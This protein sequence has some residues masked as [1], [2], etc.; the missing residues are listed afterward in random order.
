MFWVHRVKHSAMIPTKFA[1]LGGGPDGLHKFSYKITNT[2]A[3][4]PID[5]HEVNDVKLLPG[6]GAMYI[7]Q[8]DS[9]SEVC[10]LDATWTRTQTFS[11]P[12]AQGLRI[13]HDGTQVIVLPNNG[14]LPLTPLSLVSGAWVVGSPIAT[15]GAAILD[16]VWSVDYVYA[17]GY[18]GQ[19]RYVYTL[20]DGVL[21]QRLQVQA[22]AETLLPNP[23]RYYVNVIGRDANGNGLIVTA[24]WPYGTW[25]STTVQLG[26]GEITAAKDPSGVNI[27]ASTVGSSALYVL[28][29]GTRTD[30]SVQSTAQI[31]QKAPQPYCVAPLPN[32]MSCLLGCLSGEVVVANQQTVNNW[33]VDQFVTVST[34]TG[35]FVSPSGMT[36]LAYNG[37]EADLGI[38]TPLVLGADGTW[39]AGS[40]LEISLNC[41]QML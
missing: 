25:T 28:A 21:T 7:R 22:L 11:V 16:V 9:G 37:E 36:A 40:I 34:P 29:P 27:F 26:T 24:K 3:L 30:L 17:L 38:L 1:F 6:G 39:S 12:G 13:A 14:L 20:A 10:V 19:G 32:G 35:L 4:A 23:R 41:V 15:G 31:G 33:V 18:T 2:W 8:T 5:L